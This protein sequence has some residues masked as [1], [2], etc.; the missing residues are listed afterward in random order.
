LRIINKSTQEN[1]M[2]ALEQFRIALDSFMTEGFQISQQISLNLDMQTLTKIG[3]N[4]RPDEAWTIIRSINEIKK[5]KSVYPL[6]DDI[7]IAFNQQQKVM[8]SSA[9]LSRDFFYR[10][11]YESK[12]MAINSF[13]SLVEKP[14]M[15]KIVQVNNKLFLFR[16]SV[17]HV[18]DGNT[19]TLGVIY[20]KDIFDDYF[21]SSHEINGGK[22]FIVQANNQLVY[23]SGESNT[24]PSFTGNK[25]VIGKNSY[26]VISLDSQVMNWTYLYFIPESLQKAEARRIQFLTLAGLLIC[27]FFALFL[28]YKLSMRN[29]FPVRN[30]MTLLSGQEEPV[31]G[32]NEFNLIERKI[33]DTQTII[34]NNFAALKKYYI[35]NLLGKPF[36]PVNGKREMERYGI[37]LDGEWIIVVIFTVSY[38]IEG[39][40]LTE[41]ESE[42]INS[43]VHEV[44]RIFTQATPEAGEDFT[45]EMIDDGEHAA[46]IVNWSGDRD[47]FINHLETRIEHT[48]EEAA[49]FKIP[50]Q[51]AMGGP[52]K[53]L[54]G[55][56]YSNMEAVET[57][58]YL[59]PKSRQTTLHYRD[60]EYSGGIYRYSFETEQK[61]V[62]LVRLG[63]GDA[64]CAVLRQIWAE[65]TADNR[66]G[67]MNRLLAYNL[68]GT[69]V[70]G[71]IKDMPSNLHPQRLNFEN[72]SSDE[73]LNSLEKAAM[74]I[75]TI[76]SLLLSQ[77]KSDHKMSSE[78]QKYIDTQFRDPN[79]NVSQ[80]SY[81]FSM[82]PYYLATIFKEGTGKNLL[83]YI[84]TLRV[85]EGK[86][87]LNEGCKVNEAAVK[88]GF[89]NAG[90]FIRVFKKFTGVTPGL[91]KE[92]T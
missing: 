32:E 30:L 79:I 27:F 14:P 22:I 3:D 84:N 9:Y 64:V 78:I 86:K 46:A 28:S 7:L 61:L 6:V 42:L 38:P 74:E 31:K 67:Y 66:F 56:Y 57:L 91:Y 16:P 55:I 8:N 2:S 44:I 82:T 23:G 81:H 77:K 87:L 10:L 92:G 48:Q 20:D 75:C 29:Y 85:E 4:P 80:T 62:N 73:L 54:D 36:D 60:I 12:T 76:N 52:R 68:L 18:I 21:F 35:N 90:A 50:V 65:N 51:T 41:S 47:D 88:C 89:R 37:K 43:L 40:T 70:K 34:G 59:D 11:F 5:V 53:G 72:A 33:K 24:L 26:Y 39:R 69:L 13:T 83:E 15:N 19:V 58:K 71:I 45:I 17:Q 63:D 49:Q 25:G 1:S